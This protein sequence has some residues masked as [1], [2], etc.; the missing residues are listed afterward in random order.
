MC[1]KEALYIF[2]A[3]YIF[4]GEII[5]NNTEIMSSIYEKYKNEDGFLYITYEGES[6]F[7]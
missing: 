1:Y 2:I 5:P 3:F 7:G 6:T 4:I